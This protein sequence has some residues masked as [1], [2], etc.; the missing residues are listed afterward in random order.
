M[1]PT[2]AALLALCVF[3]LAGCARPLP[4]RDNASTLY[5]DVERLVSLREAAGWDIDRYEIDAILPDVLMSLCHVLP[6]QRSALLD[7]INRRM[8]ELGGPVEVAYRRNGNSLGSVSEL[9]TLSRV[10][11]ALLRASEDASEDCPFWIDPKP[12]FA[13][14]QI[15][16]HRWQFTVTGGGQGNLVNPSNDPELQFGGS[17]RAALGYVMGRHVA[18][19][20]G[21]Q[22]GGG[23]SVPR[24]DSGM[25]TSLELAL[26]TVLPVIV[27]YSWINTYIEFDAGYLAHASEDNWRQFDHGFHLGF[28]VG[29]RAMRL[30]WLFP[31]AA[32]GVS[33]ERTFASGDDDSLDM[34]KFGFRAVADIDL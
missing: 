32:F 27:R 20:G 31:G 6:E 1:P 4:P 29:A 10:R 33:Y 17:G 18:V 15:S 12:K 2:V 5:R 7:W 9:L 19:Y 14:R 3:A 8:S 13:G 24:D 21:L 11:T 30:R 26:D 22:L 25:R 23:A 28:S 16:D 34:I